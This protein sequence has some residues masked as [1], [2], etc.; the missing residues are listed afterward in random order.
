MNDCFNKEEFEK[1][2]ESELDIVLKVD[3]DLNNWDEIILTTDKIRY[4]L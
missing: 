3:K 1:R 2:L 4:C